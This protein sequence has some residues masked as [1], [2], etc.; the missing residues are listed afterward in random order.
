MRYK[1]YRARSLQGSFALLNCTRKYN[2]IEAVLTISLMCSFHYKLLVILLHQEVSHF[3]QLLTLAYLLRWAETATCFK[4]R[5]F[6]VAC[7]CHYLSLPCCQI[8][9]ELRDQ[10]AAVRCYLATFRNNF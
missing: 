1:I 6:L 4:K 8:T 9:T 2:R 10:L 5:R 7:T 3:G